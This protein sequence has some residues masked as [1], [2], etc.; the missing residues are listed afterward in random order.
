MRYLGFDALRGLCAAGVAVYHVL[1]WSSQADYAVWGRYFVYF[2]FV[3][4][5]ASIYAGYAERIAS[6][7]PLSKFYVARYARIAPLFCAVLAVRLLFEVM[8]GAPHRD[9]LL[10][11]ILNLSLLFGFAAPG[12]TSLLAGGWSLGIEF[13]FYLLF[14]LIPLAL[15]ARRLLPAACVALAV[16]LAFVSFAAPDDYITDNNWVLYSNPAA[17]GFY[18]LCGCY[19]GEALRQPLERP[20]AWV[21][22]TG[23][24]AGFLGFI[25]FGVIAADNPHVTGFA[26]AVLP[27][28]VGLC[29]FCWGRLHLEGR[30]LSKLALVSGN[31]SYGVY[32]WHPIVH[33]VL[34]RTVWTEHTS[35][36]VRVGSLLPLTF[37]L[38]LLVDKY[39]ELP[40]RRLIQNWFADAS[41]ETRAEVRLRS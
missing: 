19:I 38:A 28:L 23:A 1:Y 2:F 11:G 32:L 33:T 4:S 9:L 35:T 15:G 12:A 14:P 18:F 13:V 37:A 29:V 24:I 21:A 26:G 8:R 22:R 27:C 25:V 39:Y 20:R 3:V 40:M 31:A 16:Q 10:R 7:Y 41:R 6:G 30:V 5:G 34:S 36:L 17:F